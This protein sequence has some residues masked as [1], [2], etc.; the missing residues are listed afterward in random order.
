MCSWAWQKI[1]VR[2]W[3][4]NSSSTYLRHASLS[5]ETL[6]V[7][8][9]ST[10]KT[11]DVKHDVDDLPLGFVEQAYSWCTGHIAAWYDLARENFNVSIV[12]YDLLSSGVHYSTRFDRICSPSCR[13]GLTNLLFKC[14]VVG[15][16]TEDIFPQAV[17]LRIYGSVS[18]AYHYLSV[19]ACSQPH[20]TSET[21]SVTR[22]HLHRTT[23]NG[24]RSV[25]MRT[26]SFSR[27]PV[28]PLNMWY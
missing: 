18:L 2:C 22:L 25:F 27:R 19:V 11:E 28:Y 15:P 8:K 16:G 24:K 1:P 21:A 14:A 12:R 5:G 4:I 26:G 7:R 3:A 13:G 6:F 10:L 23:P 9:D 20:S 17:L